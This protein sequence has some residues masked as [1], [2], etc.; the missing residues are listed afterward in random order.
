LSYDRNQQDG[1]SVTTSCSAATGNLIADLPQPHGRY[2]LC[3]T[4]QQNLA[5][6]D[7]GS[8]TFSYVG[9][10][11]ERINQGGNGNP[12]EPK[13]PTRAHKR[14]GVQLLRR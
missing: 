1:G 5:F 11:E 12:S 8:F 2:F 3:E 13:Q 7:T 14:P 4:H 6:F 10:R 9:Q